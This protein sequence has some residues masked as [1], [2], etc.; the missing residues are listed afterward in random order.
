MVQYNMVTDCYKNQDVCE[1][2]VDNYPCAF[3]FFPDCHK[4]QEMYDKAAYTYPSAIQFVSECYK[5]QD[6]PGLKVSFQGQP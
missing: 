6:S 3:T 1:K 2:A 4:F 5:T